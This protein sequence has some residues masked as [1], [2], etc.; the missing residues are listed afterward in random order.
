MRPQTLSTCAQWKK[1]SLKKK[2]PVTEDTNQKAAR[3]PT[4]ARWERDYSATSMGLAAGEL[5]YLKDLQ[6]WDGLQVPCQNLILISLTR[7]T[8]ESAILFPKDLQRKHKSFRDRE[9]KP[10]VSTCTWELTCSLPT[11]WTDSRSQQTNHHLPNNNT[12]HLPASRSCF[13][14]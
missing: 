7:V 2:K 1:K 4:L 5:I 14:P 6:H 11:A 13:S 10:R 8:P 9:S 3:T 12:G